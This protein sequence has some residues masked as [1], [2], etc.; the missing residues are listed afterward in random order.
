MK[1]TQLLAHQLAV[2]TAGCAL[3]PLQENKVLPV[4][5]QPN[6]HLRVTP[7]A[8]SL[9]SL[10]RGRHCESGKPGRSSGSVPWLLNSRMAAYSRGSCRGGATWLLCPHSELQMLVMQQIFLSSPPPPNQ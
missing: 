5:Q 8:V 7:P 4:S 2:A 9:G 3:C 1:I 10:P 6:A